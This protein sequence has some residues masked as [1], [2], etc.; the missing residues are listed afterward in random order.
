MKYAIDER[1]YR[2]EWGGPLGFTRYFKYRIAVLAWI[3][4]AVFRGEKF[5]FYDRG[6]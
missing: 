4:R 1:R 2:V 3:I 6:F 5:T